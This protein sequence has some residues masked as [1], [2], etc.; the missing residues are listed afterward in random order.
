MASF[1]ACNIATHRA[2]EPEIFHLAYFKPTRGSL[3]ALRRDRKRVSLL[4]PVNEGSRQGSDS[5]YPEAI[6][7]SRN[8]FVSAFVSAF[9]STNVNNT[10]NG[11]KKKNLCKR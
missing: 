4:K 9:V 6:N 7:T 5:D 3:A 8:S 10:Q 2:F 1:S 11:Q